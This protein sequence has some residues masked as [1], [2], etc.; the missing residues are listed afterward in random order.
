MGRFAAGKTAPEARTAKLFVLLFLFIGMGRAGGNA[1]YYELVG[2][3]VELI[4]LNYDRVLFTLTPVLSTSARAGVA[5]S[6]LEGAHHLNLPTMLN[7][8]IGRRR[9]KLEVGAGATHLFT[10]DKNN[11]DS[12]IR[13]VPRG[14]ASLGY[15]RQRDEL[16]VF[17]R[18]TFT[19]LFSVRDRFLV[20]L[21]GASV[22]ASF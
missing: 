11:D 14:A 4:N 7:L 16:G 1:V 20:P 3:S 8:L 10:V 18:V 21:F 13:Y 9:H 15:R 17:V 2:S 19:P 5:Y 12:G 22:G 6:P